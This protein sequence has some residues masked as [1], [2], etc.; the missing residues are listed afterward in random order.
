[1]VS[2]EF[3]DFPD[4]FPIPTTRVRGN[5]EQKFNW[6]LPNDRKLRL[7]HFTRVLGKGP[8]APPDIPDK[9]AGSL[10]FS[11]RCYRPQ[12]GTVFLISFSNPAYRYQICFMSSSFAELSAE[13]MVAVQGC[14]ITLSCSADVSFL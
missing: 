2:R 9:V 11:H 7:G 12:P 3:S 14:R 10:G 8:S 1:M 5:G 6:D 4:D 13:R